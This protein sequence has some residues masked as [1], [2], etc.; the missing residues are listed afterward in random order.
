MPAETQRR[1]WERFGLW[2]EQHRQ[3]LHALAAYRK[4]GNYDALLRVIRSDAG[5]LLASLKPEDVL[6]A[7]DN[8]PAETLKAYPFAILVLMRRMFTWRQIPKML[9]LKALLL[10]AIRRASGTVRR[11]ARQSAGGMRSHSELSLLQRHQRHEP[12]APQRQRAD[13]P[14]RHQHPV[15]RRLDLRLTVRSDDVPPCTGSDGKRACGDGRVHAPLLQG[16]ESPRAGCRDHHAR[17]G[18]VLSGALHGCPH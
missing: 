12:P 6:N 13:V 16:H 15:E 3:Y 10:T 7:L 9:E 17:R 11:R 14:P 2:Y 8:C 1:Y 4:S 18:A 5:I